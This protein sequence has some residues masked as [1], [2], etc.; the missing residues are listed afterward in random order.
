M[1]ESTYLNTRKL[2]SAA[3]FFWN[4]V[5]NILICDLTSQLLFSAIQLLCH[6][7]R[8]RGRKW[9]RKK[10]LTGEKKFGRFFFARLD[11]SR[12][13]P[14]RTH[15]LWSP[16]MLLCK[17]KVGS[18]DRNSLNKS[19]D[20]TSLTSQKTA[21]SKYHNKR[22]QGNGNTHRSWNFSVPKLDWYT[23]KVM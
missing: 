16:R 15:C 11:F 17:N 21:Y 4:S 14:P 23:C 5:G 7:R 13:P 6:P 10:V 12:P 9:G 18:L 8:P 19:V 2:C 20:T 3:F 1:A 22:Q